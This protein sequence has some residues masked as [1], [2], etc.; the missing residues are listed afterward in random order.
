MRAKRPNNRVH[1]FRYWDYV[2]RPISSTRGNG[3]ERDAV[4]SAYT[5]WALVH[6]LEGWQNLYEG[7]QDFIPSCRG[8]SRTSCR[9]LRRLTDSERQFTTA[10]LSRKSATCRVT[11]FFDGSSRPDV[12]SAGPMNQPSSKAKSTAT[13]SI[14]HLPLRRASSAWRS[15]SC[16]A[17][18]RSGDRPAVHSAPR[19]PSTQTP[20][21]EAV[22]RH[23]ATCRACSSPPA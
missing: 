10:L 13:V 14:R 19:I 2:A 22:W 1:P 7:G 3:D 23:F 21:S 15:T 17:M 9:S 20:C 18:R 16:F 5:A 4:L 8:R 12:S 6:R 11:V